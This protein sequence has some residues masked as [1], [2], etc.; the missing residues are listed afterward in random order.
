MYLYKTDV[1][2]L[3]VLRP[4]NMRLLLQR[5]ASAA[6]EHLRLAS[7]GVVQ[8][9]DGQIVGVLPVALL[10][11]SATVLGAYTSHEGHALEH[12]TSVREMLELFLSELGGNTAHLVLSAGPNSGLSEEAHIFTQ[13]GF[14]VEALGSAEMRLVFAVR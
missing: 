9:L 12:R 1:S 4:A 3:S 10:G 8:Q 14:V 2:L 5:S 11:Y 7:H 6:S 13:C